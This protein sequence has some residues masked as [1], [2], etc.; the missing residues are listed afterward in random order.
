MVNYIYVETGCLENTCWCTKPKRKAPYIHPVP[1]L[2]T[3]A[4]VPYT[5]FTWW[6]LMMMIV[7]VLVE[8]FVSFF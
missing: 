4:F 6:L 3:S 2:T 7:F 1:L 8:H 5:Q